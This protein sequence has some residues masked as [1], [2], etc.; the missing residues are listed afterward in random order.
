MLVPAG[1]VTTWGCGGDNGAG[2]VW[3]SA[4]G[5]GP[6]YR[7]SLTARDV[8][9]VGSGLGTVTGGVTGAGTFS[10]GSLGITVTASTGSGSGEGADAAFRAACFGLRTGA[11]T[12]ST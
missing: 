9:P 10:A 12:D 7:S 11:G 8:T 1:S 3:A 5:C 6:W 4:V 2:F